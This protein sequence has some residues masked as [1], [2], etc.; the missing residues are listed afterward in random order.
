MD[1]RGD[2][3]SCRCRHGHFKYNRP[4]VATL[5]F[6]GRMVKVELELS[7]KCTLIIFIYILLQCKVGAENELL[8]I[9]GMLDTW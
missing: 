6:E 8:F 2:T 5:G 1:E 7:H 4:S 9:P 3:L